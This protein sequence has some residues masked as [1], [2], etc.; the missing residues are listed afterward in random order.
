MSDKYVPPPTHC[1]HSSFSQPLLKRWNHEA[2]LSADNFIYPI[3]VSDTEEGSEPI[4]SLPGQSRWSIA[5]LPEL[6]DPLVK[7]GLK[8]VMIFG[9]IT[10]PETKVGNACMYNDFPVCS[11]IRF[12]AKNYPSLLICA[13]VCLCTFSEDGHCG[14]LRESGSLDNQPSIDALAKMSVMYAEAGVHVIAPSDMMDGR[15]G[16]IKHALYAAGFGNTV[17]V[18]AY[19]AKFASCFYGP[20]RDAACSGAKKGD[21]SNYQLPPPARGLAIR[22]IQRDIDEGAD[23]VMVKPGMPYL[24][25]VRDCF[26][27]ANKRG[28]PTAIYQVSGEYAMLYHAA[29][30]GAMDLTSAVVESCVSMRRAGANIIITYFINELLDYCNSN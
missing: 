10:K 24:D 15:I 22:A 6:L 23:F 7:K 4:N 19:S 9:V 21:R 28:I 27:I 1:L 30:A 11:A 26:E 3:F 2:T 16:A 8:S 18:M 17:A 13:D 20:F 29:K 12:I 25:I 14:F 5:A